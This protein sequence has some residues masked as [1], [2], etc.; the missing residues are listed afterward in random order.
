MSS[1]TC[2]FAIVCLLCSSVFVRAKLDIDETTDVFDQSAF[3]ENDLWS[4]LYQQC[5]KRSSYGCV[6]E[7]LT[8]YLDSALESDFVTDAVS[9]T[10]N[11]NNYT[12]ICARV[13]KD[14]PGD[15]NERAERKLE[16]NEDGFSEFIEKVEEVEKKEDNFRKGK[17]LKESSTEE[18]SIPS[19]VDSQNSSQNSTLPESKNIRDLTDVMYDRGLKYL[20]THDVDLAIPS[21]MFGGGKVRISPRGFDDDGGAIVKLNVLPDQPQ[22]GRLFFKHIKKLFRKKLMSS[23]LAAMLILKLLKLKLMFFLPVLLGV[24]T[25]KKI[26]LKVLLFLFP[27]LAH[28]FKLC[29]YYHHKHAKYHH[30][31]HQIAHHHHHIPVPVYTPVHTAPGELPAPYPASYDATGPGVYHSRT[32]APG[33]LADLAAWGLGEYP[34]AWDNNLPAATDPPRY[35][36][37]TRPQQ[38]VAAA[39]PQYAT[40]ANLKQLYASA[41]AGGVSKT[42]Q[43]QYTQ[44]YNQAVTSRLQA[45]TPRPTATSAAS[46]VYDPFYSPML[47]RL[48]AVF[49]SLGVAD[50]GCR[51]RVVCSMY[52]N[53][54]RF[55]PH[56]NLVSAELSRDPSELQK[57]LT[58]NNAVVRFYRYLQA[59]RDGQEH[60]ECL[61]L[62]PACSV[63]TE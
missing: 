31:H 7:S 27:A 59:A 10:Q 57:P 39:T 26:L 3:G 53:P 40:T 43:Q 42:Q 30:H 58:A 1:A 55:S 52:K 2:T 44:Q 47:Q 50:E 13:K 46:A 24:G 32:E 23:M 21:F 4:T 29:S 34:S 61:R 11:E 37:P 38:V 48:D 45:L 60:K 16:Y 9:F 22:E 14:H 28:L 15:F 6:Q 35:N 5:G 12:N 20:M 19:V 62:Y 25:A 63:A 36:Y 56:S 54:T 18:T 33:S 41:L 49:S 17:S 51:E 8:S